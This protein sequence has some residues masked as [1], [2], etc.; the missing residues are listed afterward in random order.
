MVSN[1]YGVPLSVRDLS[2]FIE[3][4]VFSEFDMVFIDCPTDCMGILTLDLLEMVH[5]IIFTKGD[6]SNLIYTS[7]AL[8][9]RKRVSLEVERWVMNNCLVDIEEGY[10]QEDIDFINNTMLFANGNWLQRKDM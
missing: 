10:L 9:D 4:Q 2:S 8:T 1:G 7:L 5:P 6:R 3:S